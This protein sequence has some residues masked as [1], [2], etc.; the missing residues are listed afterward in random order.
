MMEFNETLDD[1]QNGYYIIQKDSG[2]RFGIDAVLL[3]DFAKSVTGK[4]MD[5]CTGTGII[6]L[7]LV[8][9]SNAEHIDAVEIQPEIADMAKRSVEYNSL[10]EKVNIQCADLKDAP[11][12]FGKSTYDAV[13]VNPPYMRTGSGLLNETDNKTISRHEIKCNLDDVIRVSSELLKPHGRLFMVHRPSRLAEIFSAMRQYKLE[14]KI[15]RLIAPTEGKEVNLVLVCGIKCAKSD[16]KIMPTLFV[17]DEHGNYTK[18][19]DE[20]YGR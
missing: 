15:M 19:I 1:L 3:S 5:L 12:L 20:I 2:F 18:E 13:T 11:R 7:L 14:P 17:Y 6:P 8:A 4:V 9:K 16:L 10:T